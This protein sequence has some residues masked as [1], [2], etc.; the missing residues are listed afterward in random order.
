MKMLLGDMMSPME[1]IT[2]TLTS[3]A[4]RT[5]RAITVAFYPIKPIG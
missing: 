5:G 3:M 1:M 4:D 2:I